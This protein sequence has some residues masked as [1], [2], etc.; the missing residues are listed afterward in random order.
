MVLKY[1]ILSGFIVLAL[2]LVGVSRAEAWGFGIGAS[3]GHGPFRVSA[4]SHGRVEA[5]YSG[6]RGVSVGVSNSGASGSYTTPYGGT[7]GASTDGR[8]S[9]S[10]GYEVPGGSVEGTISNDGIQGS[11][12]T[13]IDPVTE[14]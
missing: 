2:F 8:V 1:R 6:S 10:Y 12:D 9:G 5:G 3:V 11:S 4:D 14:Q 7:V 13:F